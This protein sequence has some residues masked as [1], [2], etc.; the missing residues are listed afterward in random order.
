MRDP[1]FDEHAVKS[2]TNCRAWGLADCIHY[3]PDWQKRADAL[4]AFANSTGVPWWDGDGAVGLLED[5]RMALVN[6]IVG[7]VEP[8]W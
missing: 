6:G 4:Y 8:T 5:G 3:A 2:R 1:T 7:I